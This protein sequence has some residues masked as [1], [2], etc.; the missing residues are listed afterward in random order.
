MSL[1]GLANELSDR[2]VTPPS[3]L[4][5]QG[6]NLVVALLLVAFLVMGW[7]GRDPVQ[8]RSGDDLIYLSLSRSLQSGSYREIFRPSAPLHVKYP[9]G[10]PAWLVLVRQVTGDHLALIVV[11]NLLL[12]SLSLVLMFVVAR[13]LMGEWLALAFLTLMALSPALLW[14]GGSLY[15]EAL[16][17]LISTSALAMTLK[18][19]R[20]GG[21]GAVLG[22][23]A[24]A[25]LAFLTRTAGI[26]LVIGIGV[27][28]WRRRKPAELTAYGLSSAVVVGG[29]F[30]YASAASPDPSTRSYANDLANVT[31]TVRAGQLTQLAS[32]LW[33]NAVNY[34]TE[35]LPTELSVPTIPG[36]LLDNW[37]WQLVQTILLVAGIVVLWRAW[38]AAA[39]YVVLYASLLVFW[40]WPIARLLS[41]II[42]LALLLLLLGAHR[43]T[44]R[45]SVRA[46]GLT[47]GA[48]V[49]VLLF[50]AARGAID[51]V[52]KI[53]LCDRTNPYISPGCYDAETRTIVAAATYLRLHTAPTDVVLANRPVAMQFLSG[54]LS[55]PTLLLEQVPPGEAA[56]AL[57]DRKIQ[58]VLLTAVNPFERVT[59][60]GI[61]LASCT[62]FRVEAQFA[63]HAMLLEASPPDGTGADACA[64]IAE[65]I[66]ERGERLHQTP[67]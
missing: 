49:A 7:R 8:I 35:T 59:L 9:P 62:G 40:P 23:I 11:A 39:A 66:R 34:G 26:A 31:A 56:R 27:W 50:G 63:P 10:Y 58:H 43:L 60:A 2:P 33:H 20:S 36:T 13:R 12:V 67:P 51:R 52:Q 53:R 42:P 47:L 6:R 15:S 4:F 30:A 32:R 57:R 19:D 65:F 1:T 55:E 16:F 24:L 14:T 17:L 38:R 28:L 25:L 46:R 45:M 48:L 18:A 61:L 54:H 64:A 37:T 22:A 5:V 3:R 29:W 41:P 44:Q 21:R